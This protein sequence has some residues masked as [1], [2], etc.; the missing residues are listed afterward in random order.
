LIAIGSV[1]YSPE[2]TQQA[3]AYSPPEETRM[4][5]TARPAPRVPPLAPDTALARGLA[6][7]LQS[8]AFVP[9][10]VLIVQAPAEARA[11]ARIRRCR[12]RSR[13]ARAEIIAA[14]RTLDR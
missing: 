5:R 14:L 1:L 6:A 9:H 10:C 3:A 8:L 13:L 11:G 2:R 7:Y 4:N 12:D